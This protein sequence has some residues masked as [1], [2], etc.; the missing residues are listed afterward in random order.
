MTLFGL[1]ALTMELILRLFASVAL[2][3]LVGLEREITKKPAG[4]RTHVL[5]CMGACLFTIASFYMIPP[6][7]A[8]KNADYS[9]IAAGIVTGIGFIG[10]GS[11]IATKGHV[12]GVTT[13]ASL[14]IVAAIG[15][16]AG[17]GR[18]IIALIGAGL[19]FFILK[20]GKVEREL[21]SDIIRKNRPM[22]TKGKGI[23]VDESSRKLNIELRLPEGVSLGDRKI[24]K[25]DE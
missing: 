4:L 11:I 19:S 16:M 10:A 12:R 1:D 24:R 18:Y 9:R 5:V 6:D 14:W 22:K 17:M 3:A 2:G 13:A 23:H 25:G 8:L 7:T 21:E 20:I 15:L